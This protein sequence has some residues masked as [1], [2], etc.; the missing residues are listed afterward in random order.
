MQDDT[1][2]SN[3]RMIPYFS[4][5]QKKILQNGICSK[6]WMVWGKKQLQSNTQWLS[7]TLYVANNIPAYM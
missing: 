5:P 6:I 2:H 3:C 7:C 4:P 1:L